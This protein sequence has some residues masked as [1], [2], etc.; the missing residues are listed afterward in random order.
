[1][2]PGIATP[3]WIKH[4]INVIPAQAGIFPF[5]SPRS[6]AEFFPEGNNGSTYL[7]NLIFALLNTTCR[8]LLSLKKVKDIYLKKLNFHVVS[9]QLA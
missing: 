7:L 5:Q 6:K 4:F 8:E 1:M 9:Y 3:D 2:A